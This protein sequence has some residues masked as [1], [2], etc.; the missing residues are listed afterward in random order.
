M[1]DP[2]SQPGVYDSAASQG[3][4]NVGRRWA[5]TLSLLGVD[6]SPMLSEEEFQQAIGGRKIEYPEGGMSLSQVQSHIQLHDESLMYDAM[7][8][9]VNVPHHAASFVLNLGMN[10]VDPTVLGSVALS[11][12]VGLLARAAPAAG[13]LTAAG[14]N[15]LNAALKKAGAKGA[16]SQAIAKGVLA[17]TPFLGLDY[18]IEEEGGL[19][20]TP[21]QMAMSLGLSG[22][23]GLLGTAIARPI[24]KLSREKSYKRFVDDVDDILAR[25]DAGELNAN[26]VSRSM[27]GASDNVA[28]NITGLLNDVDGGTAEIKF[29]GKR[30]ADQWDRAIERLDK[31]GD[32]LKK[33]LKV[34]SDI[35]S[36]IPKIRARYTQAIRES[37]FLD[38]PVDEL[39]AG[40][41][42]A[43][44]EDP[45]AAVHARRD[46]E[47][48]IRDDFAGDA[49]PD[50]LEEA[51]GRSQK[52]ANARSANK[53]QFDAE[54][55][56][57]TRGRGKKD[58]TDIE[59]AQAKEFPE[60]QLDG[61][62][63]KDAPPI[64]KAVNMIARDI[65]GRGDEV[66]SDLADHLM[67]RGVGL[68]RSNRETLD[69][70]REFSS[71]FESRMSDL[72]A[73]DRMGAKGVGLRNDLGELQYG[74]P[75]DYVRLENKIEEKLTQA[76]FERPAPFLESQP[77]VEM[78]RGQRTGDEPTVH[79]QPDIDAKKAELVAMD[80]EISA[81]A[82]EVDKI[83][84]ESLE[85]SLSSCPIVTPSTRS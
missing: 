37:G 20:Y 31:D 76:D 49:S 36:E 29:Q 9:T 5:D 55:A 82:L 14:L 69:A 60:P 26:E 57:T 7:V 16:Y 22:G 53:E 45:V 1:S 41:A 84:E 13:R 61:L 35:E 62:K 48:S 6:D 15:G 44:M 18:M 77:S 39:I 50:A 63:F 71:E 78:A 17:E 58:H 43:D 11:G 32:T 79:E 83:L 24:Q 23:V 68:G 12:G 64:F 65:D 74:T 70:I 52:S 46:I 42:V 73:A 54:R 66:A 4:A 8:D 25:Y 21:A 27:F 10:I 28:K 75:D 81:K 3:L 47:N 34:V 80:D 72:I 38:E 40:K 56:D 51:S 85:A 67:S 59:W 19:Q 30:V 2:W 33:A